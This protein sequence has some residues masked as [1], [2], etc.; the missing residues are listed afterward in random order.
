MFQ[1]CGKKRDATGGVNLDDAGLC[2]PP[3]AEPA[4]TKR[5]PKIGFK[6]D[7]TQAGELF[8]VR[9][10]YLYGDAAVYILYI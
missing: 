3:D 7:T 2:A 9:R 10:G 1:Q 6:M 4:S 8:R 5:F